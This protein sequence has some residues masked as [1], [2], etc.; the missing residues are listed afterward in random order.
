MAVVSFW[1][2]NANFVIISEVGS[3]P[4]GTLDP[5]LVRTGVEM[6]RFERVA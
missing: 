6:D 2:K 5:Y 4:M 3:S 1:L